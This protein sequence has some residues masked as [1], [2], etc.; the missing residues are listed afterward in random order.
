MSGSL[1]ARAVAD[2]AEAPMGWRQIT[3]FDGEEK[4]FF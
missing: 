2:M 3:I 1:L 4:K